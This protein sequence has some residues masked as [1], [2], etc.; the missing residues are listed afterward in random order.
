MNSD[1]DIENISLD[2]AMMSYSIVIV[3]YTIR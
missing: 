2:F 3:I 1:F